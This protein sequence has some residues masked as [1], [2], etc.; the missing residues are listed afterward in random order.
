M[1]VLLTIFIALISANTFAQTGNYLSCQGENSLFEIDYLGR[2]LNHFPR[3]EIRAHYQNTG[4]KRTVLSKCY[5]YSNAARFYGNTVGH[6]GAEVYGRLDENAQGELTG[7]LL[8]VE[9]VTCKKRQ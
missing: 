5:R 7:Y 1:R 2:D 4:V 8:Y 6:G 9:G 3:C